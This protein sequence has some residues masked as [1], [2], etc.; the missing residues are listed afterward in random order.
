MKHRQNFSFVRGLPIIQ[1][2]Q[3][4]G[5]IATQ[6]DGRPISVP[7]GNTYKTLSDI[8]ISRK[9]KP[10]RQNPKLI[11]IGKLCKEVIRL[12][13][14]AEFTRDG[15]RIN[16]TSVQI[17]EGICRYGSTVVR[18]LNFRELIKDLTLDRILTLT[19]QQEQYLITQYNKPTK[20]KKGHE[21]RKF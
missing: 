18:F 5:E 9:P 2:G 20:K 1:E 12:G 13:I 15:I 10:V 21:Y 11:D 4:K 16:K 6:K 7:A 8:G 19:S 14:P 3:Q 17:G